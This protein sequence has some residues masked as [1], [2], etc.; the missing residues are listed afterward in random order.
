MPHCNHVDRIRA[1][2]GR[3]WGLRIFVI[4]FR[5][6]SKNIAKAAWSNNVTCDL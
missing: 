2:E 5:D 3:L 6:G 1:T 4:V